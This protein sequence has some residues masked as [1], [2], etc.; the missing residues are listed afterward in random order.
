MLK[1]INFHSKLKKKKKGVC[2]CVC[3][4]CL[5]ACLKLFFQL[6]TEEGNTELK[7]A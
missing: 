4:C 3:C 7:K 1:L 2:F 6:D 5:F